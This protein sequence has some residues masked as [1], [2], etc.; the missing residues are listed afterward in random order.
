MIGDCDKNEVLTTPLRKHGPEMPC[1]ERKRRPG[2]QGVSG[3][4]A[5]RGRDNKNEGA[6]SER[7][8]RRCMCYGGALRLGR[9]SH[10][11]TSELGFEG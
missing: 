11:A 3:L 4:V 10:G 7:S 6:L 1:R 9:A 8:T 5:K 2:P